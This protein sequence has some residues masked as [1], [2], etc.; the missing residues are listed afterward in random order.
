M[1]H[2]EKQEER[3]AGCLGAIRLQPS[4]SYIDA[5][6]EVVGREAS[7]GPEELGTECTNA[8]FKNAW[9]LYETDHDPV[10]Q[11]KHYTGHKSG[12]ECIQITEHMNFCLGNALKYIWRSGLKDSEN[13]VQDLEKAVWYLNREITRLKGDVD[14]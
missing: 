13:N 8:Y 7:E 12:V 1:S 9:K 6:P 5:R 3:N 2:Y 11:P 10:N 4:S 14:V